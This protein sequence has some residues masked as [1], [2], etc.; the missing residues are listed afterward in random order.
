MGNPDKKFSLSYE[1]VSQ[2][3]LIKTTPERKKS[4]SSMFEIRRMGDC[5]GWSPLLMASQSAGVPASPLLTTPPKNTSMTRFISWQVSPKLVL[6]LSGP[7]VLVNV[8]HSPHRNSHFGEKFIKNYL[9]MF[10]SL[11]DHFN[12]WKLTQVFFSKAKIWNC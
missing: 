3:K 8:Q 1:M 12:F 5:G 10:L 2:L 4:K 6:T 7:L 9:H 11:W